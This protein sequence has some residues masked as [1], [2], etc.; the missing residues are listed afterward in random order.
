MKQLLKQQ[1]REFAAL[2]YLSLF[3]WWHQEFS[4]V[5]AK[6]PDRGLKQ[7]GNDHASFIIS[8]FEG[9]KHHVIFCKNNHNNWLETIYI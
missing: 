2:P 5:E 6:V 7:R 3:Q 4:D 8:L 1:R 9:Q